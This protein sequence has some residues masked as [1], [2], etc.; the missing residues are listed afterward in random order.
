MTLNGSLRPSKRESCFYSLVIFFE[1]LCKAA[2][3]GN[4]LL[5]HLFQPRIKA[6]PFPLSQHGREF[7]DQLIGLGNFWISR[8]QLCE[9][10]L[11]PLQP[12]LFFQG[13]PVSHLTSRWWALWGGFDRSGI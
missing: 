8:T 4:A 13:D 3:F 1:R 11:L 6:F 5:F 9:I 7:L 10:L 12:L 2:E